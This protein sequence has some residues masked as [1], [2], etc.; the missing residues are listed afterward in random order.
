MGDWDAYPSRQINA[1]NPQ[2]ETPGNHAV[3]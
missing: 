1:G 2:R 3:E